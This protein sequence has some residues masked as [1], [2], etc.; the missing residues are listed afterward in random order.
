MDDSY[1][2]R[3]WKCSSPS[4]YFGKQVRNSVFPVTIHMSTADQ[5]HKMQKEELDPYLMT[6][7][8]DM[9]KVT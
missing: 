6:L 1:A 9:R 8:I 2:T 4:I 5:P 7:M 3:E